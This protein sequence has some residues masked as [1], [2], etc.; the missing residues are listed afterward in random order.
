MTWHMYEYTDRSQVAKLQQ[1]ISQL[2]R[3]VWLCR[4]QWATWTQDAQWRRAGERV[5]LC[6]SVAR[7]AGWQVSLW[8]TRRHRRW[9]RC[10]WQCSS[11]SIAV[12]GSV[13]DGRKRIHRSGEWRKG[14]ARA[15]NQRADAR[16]PVGCKRNT[17]DRAQSY[18]VLCLFGRRK[19]HN[20]NGQRSSEVGKT[21]RQVSSE[22]DSKNV[23]L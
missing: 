12:A 19:S 18:E 8:V 7:S 22:L 6:D 20:W 9:R 4:R 10:F 17:V 16:P 14:K 3:E 11:S 1:S 5:A 2:T 21:L 15:E 23:Y 13:L